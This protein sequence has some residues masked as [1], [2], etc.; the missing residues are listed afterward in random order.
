MRTEEQTH[1]MIQKG[2]MR[3]KNP[4]M[5]TYLSY[6]RWGGHFKWP[7]AKCKHFWLCWD[8]NPGNCLLQRWSTTVTAA[9]LQRVAALSILRTSQVSCLLTS[10]T[11]EKN[12]FVF[13]CSRQITVFSVNNY[14]EKHNWIDTFIR[15]GFRLLNQQVSASE[16]LISKHLSSLLIG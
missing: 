2:T 5:N 6:N 16:T 15:S 10:P 13:C 14:W 8:R 3:K 7:K 4:L 12:W 11:S 9:V 1:A